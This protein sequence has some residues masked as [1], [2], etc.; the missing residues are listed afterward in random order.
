[1]VGSG[2]GLK[3]ATIRGIVITW[4]T[5]L[6]GCFILSFAFAVV[7]FFI[8]PYFVKSLHSQYMVG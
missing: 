4:F 6:P 7:A 8:I 1:M 5:T 3:F 2:A